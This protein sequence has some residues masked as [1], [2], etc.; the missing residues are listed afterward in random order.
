MLVYGAN[1]Y[2]QCLSTQLGDDAV[3]LKCGTRGTLQA[4]GDLR[5]EEKED[6]STNFFVET[7]EVQFDGLQQAHTVPIK[8]TSLQPPPMEVLNELS[9]GIKLP[10]TGR[11]VEQ[12]WALQG[13]FAAQSN[14]LAELMGYKA[15]YATQSQRD[16]VCDFHIFNLTHAKSICLGSVQAAVFIAVM[17]EMLDMMKS[18]PI[19]P[20]SRP[21]ECCTVNACFKEFERLLLLHAVRDPPH[22]LDIFRASEVRLLTDFAS[23]TVFKH[24]LLYQYCTNSDREVQ[25]LRFGMG[26]E[27]PMPL[28]DL[29]AATLKPKRSKSNEEGEALDAQVP[30]DASSED[31]ELTEEQ[32]IELLVQEKLKE[33]EARL[34]AK[35]AAREEAF[36]A[37]IEEENAKG[38][39]K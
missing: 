17:Q 29:N 8:H 37:R 28:P 30:P 19:N 20:H 23:T 10:L 18:P 2:Q 13:D 11:Q 39:K 25:T 21:G 4:V 27:R 14:L 9:T 16:I 12:L 38:K 34:E 22:R 7:V 1:F 3:L 6:G 26:L 15:S 32:E 36:L 33:T 5:N 35:L 24:F 31:K